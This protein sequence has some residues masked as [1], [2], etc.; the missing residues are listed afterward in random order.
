MALQFIMGGSGAGKTRFLYESLIREAQKRPDRQFVVIV[1]EQFTMQTQKEIVSLH[2]RRGTMNIDIVSFERLAYRVFEELAVVNPAV[3]DDMGK[4]MVLRKVAAEKGKQMGIFRGHLGQAGFIGQLKSMVSELYQYGVSPEQLDEMQAQAPSPLLKAKLKDLAAVYRGFQEYIDQKFI[5]AEEILGE[6]CRVFPRSEKMRGSVVVLDGYTGFTPVQYRLLE[7]MLVCCRDVKVAVT[8]ERAAR[9]YEKSGIQNLFYMSKETVRRLSALAEKNHVKREEDC[10]LERRPYPRFS[11]GELDFLEQ[12]LYRYSRDTWKEVP[13]DV[14]LYRAL[15]PREEIAFVAGR[16]ERMVREQG[17]R[18]RD[19][20]VVTGDL[21]SYGK[22]AV[23]QFQEKE[24]PF[25]L[26]D[27]KSILEHP[28]VEF[29][30]AALEVTVK[31]FSYESMFRYLKCAL[32]AAP[33]ER[34]MCDRMENYCLALGIRGWRRWSSPWELVYRGGKHVNMEELNAFREKTAAPLLRLREELRREDATVGSMT[35][36]LTEF[37]TEMGAEEKVLDWSCRFQEAGEYQLADE[38]S[39]VYGLVMDLFDRLAALLGDEK[40]SVREFGEIL[41]AG[42]GEIQVGVIPATVDRVVVG[43]I[44]RTRLDHIQVLFFVGVNDGIVPVKKEKGGILS[45][46]DREFLEQNDLELAPTARKE[47]FLQRFYLY[48]AL[49]KPERKLVLSFSSMNQAGKGLRPSSLIRELARLF[50]GLTAGEAGGE[51][52]VS[53]PQEGKRILAERLRSWNGE[54]DPAFLELYRS[55]WNDEKSRGWLREMVEA[56]FFSHE[57]RGIG[58]AAAREL[59]GKIL[60][61]SV[62]RLEQYEA[63]AYAHFLSYGLELQERQE[64]ELKAADMGNLFH[65]AID[66]AFKRAAERGRRLQ[67]M[68]SRERDALADEAVEEAVSGYGGDIMKSSARNAYLGGKVGRITRRTLWALAEQLKKG[69]FS[70]AGFEVSFSS[71]DNLKAMKIALTE[72]EA[73]H[74]QGRIDRMDLCED[75]THVYVKIIDY[76]SG[77]TS[78]DLAALYYGLQLQ[79]VVYMDAAMELMERK[80]PGKEIVPAGIFYYHIDDPVVD[81]EEAA[82]KEDVDRLV[83]KKLR[84]DGL[85]NSELEVISLMDREIEKASDIIP[86]AVKDG[87]VDEVKSS[88][89]NRKRFGHLCGF[90]RKSLKQAGRNILNGDTAADPYKQGNRTACDYCPYHSVCGFDRRLP[91]YE[92]RRLKERTPQEIWE[93]IEKEDEEEGR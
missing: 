61:G 24:I 86:V 50:P 10:W 3:L 28:L 31:D 6:L 27:K 15:N 82:T 37:L 62:T 74:L 19:I 51:R 4:S 29:I 87:L 76:K 2:P 59:Y 63:C 33:E 12:K 58:R 22:E 21:E 84:M 65:C 71:I 91:G 36:A 38:Y 26:D 64:Y 48:L 35:A 45:E 67:D 52:S 56:A 81:G 77:S 79:L 80:N 70:P 57:D 7:Q 88:V 75:E 40:S 13:E 25:F 60:S 18:Y 68:D 30:R 32:A 92:Y 11:G 69:E 83:L 43:D 8:V 90:V 39:Q 42:F 14:L 5:T 49:T 55:F 54:E 46:S 53:S 20:A 9:P 66:T 16:I 34:E 47:S 1:P 89:A 23:F 41:D 93:E 72:D 44:T 73:L 78:F 17:L 85:V